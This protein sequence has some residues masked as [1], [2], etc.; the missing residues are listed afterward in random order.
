VSIDEFDNFLVGV[1]IEKYPELTNVG[2]KRF[3]VL[4]EQNMVID[5][6]EKSVC[7]NI[8]NIG[9]Y[10]FKSA[11]EFLEAQE[12]VKGAWDSEKGEIYLSHV[13]SYMLGQKHY[14]SYKE[15][16]GYEDW[17]LITDW[18]SVMKRRRTYF[19]DID[20]VVFKNKGRYGTVRW[21]DE[22]IPLENNVRTLRRLAGEGAQIVF[23]TSRS[24][25][26]RA[27][28]ERSLKTLDISWHSIVMG[29]NHSQRVMINDFANTNPYP[30]SRAIN[31]C[32]DG[33]DLDKYMLAGE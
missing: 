20:G 19:V 18:Y 24:E 23:C 4:N 22:D 27:D 1:D 33:D 26:H 15:A 8:I 10:G 30:S 13:A 9:V 3:I 14:F 31:I 12:T 28:L 5:I 7:S 6:I 25:S 11:D 16:A 17:G 2:G 29:C 21:G 32:R